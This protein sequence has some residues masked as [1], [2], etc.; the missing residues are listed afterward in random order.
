MILLSIGIASIYWNTI[1]LINHN[2]EQAQDVDKRN[3]SRDWGEAQLNSSSDLGTQL[4]FVE[5]TKWLWL[6]YHTVHHLFPHID[7]SKHPG[8]QNILIETCKEFK[9]KYEAG[10]F[11]QMYK[12]MVTTFSTPRHLGKEAKPYYI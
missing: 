12:E 1:A 3:N 10:T 5:S 2:T 6:N 11:V 7:M 8:V 9:I 4:S